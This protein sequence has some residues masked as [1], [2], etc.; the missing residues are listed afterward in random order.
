MRPT[1]IASVLLVL[2][3]AECA[4]EVWTA[5]RGGRAGVRLVDEHVHG[6][7]LPAVERGALEQEQGAQPVSLRAPFS[8]CGTTRTRKDAAPPASA[9]SAPAAAKL[10]N[11]SN[12]TDAPAFAFRS[13]ACEVGDPARAAPTSARA[14]Y[15]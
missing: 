1:T 12:R 5:L 9:L 3:E 4:H 8:A 7:V 15:A 10:L 13:S 14:Q 2:E 11:G 6:E